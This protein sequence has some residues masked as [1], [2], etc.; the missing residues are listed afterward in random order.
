MGDVTEKEMDNLTFKS[1]TVL[2]DVHLHCPNKRHLMVRLNAVGQPVFLSYFKLLWNTDDQASKKY[3]RETTVESEHQY[4][5]GDELCDKD[6]D[7]LKCERELNTE[8]IEALLDEDGDLEVVRRPQ[9]ASDLEA[10]DLVRDRVYP[11]ILM[12]GKETAFE[13]EEQE[14]TRSDVVKIEHTMATPLEDVGKQVWR[15]A[16]LLADYILFKRDVFRSCTVLELGGGTGITSI[17]MGTVANRVYCTDVGEDLLAM[18]EQNVALNKHLMEPGGGEI[19]VKELDWLKDEFCTDPEALYSWSEEEIAD[20]HDHCT[21][22]MA[23]DV[24]YDDDLTDAFFR[25][26]YRITHNLKHSCTVFLAIE[27]RLN[28]TLRHMDVTC[29]AYSH[30]RNTLNDLENRQD[31]KMKYSVEPIKPDF[32]QFLIYERIE[33]LELWKIIADQ[34]T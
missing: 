18:C 30:F 1:D 8:G 2:S 7:S 33:Q 9:S 26:L 21:V 28:F 3:A 20:L 6:G 10:E 23:A 22:I 24:F 12:K 34:L 16:F 11:V 29:E 31:G 25:M 13:D 5:S 17:I 15:A 32:C 14:C 4:R 27:K 19:K